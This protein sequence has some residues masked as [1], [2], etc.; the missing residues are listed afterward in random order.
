[1]DNRSILRLMRHI[2]QI[3]TEGDNYTVVTNMEEPFEDC[4]CMKSYPELFEIKNTKLPKT[5]QTL[6][7]EESN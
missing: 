1:M 6:N 2:H 5:Y 4:A 3:G 7:Y